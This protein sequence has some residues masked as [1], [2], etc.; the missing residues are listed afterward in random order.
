[1]TANGKLPPG[2]RRVKARGH[3]R[4]SSS[5][6]LRAGKR[7][8]CW[9]YT[10]PP[11]EHWVRRHRTGASTGAEVLRVPVQITLTCPNIGFKRGMCFSTI[12]Q[13]RRTCC[14][15]NLAAF[16]TFSER[17]VYS[18]HFT[19]LRRCSTELVPLDPG[20]LRIASFLVGKPVRTSRNGCLR[21]AAFAIVGS[22]QAASAHEKNSLTLEIAL[23]ADRMS[24]SGSS[25]GSTSRWRWPIRHGRPPRSYSMTHA[26][27]RTHS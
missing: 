1:M 9:R 10:D 24:R 21:Y 11:D 26:P 7:D 3:T 20:Y 16:D 13:Q 2:W 22:R 23:P 25:P 15:G 8:D 18:N 4:E 27:S 14:T 17:L 19:R 12:D 5:P 6:A